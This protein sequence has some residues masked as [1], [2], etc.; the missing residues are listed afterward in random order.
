MRYPPIGGI[1]H[2]LIKD[3]LLKLRRVRLK[4]APVI[5]TINLSQFS[6][7]AC[8]L[9]PEWNNYSNYDLTAD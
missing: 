5:R 1:D 8:S 6:E 9:S 2:V 3:S 7:T 4:K